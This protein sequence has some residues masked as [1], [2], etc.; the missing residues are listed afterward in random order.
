MEGWEDRNV[1]AP[2]RQNDHPTSASSC[3]LLTLQSSNTPILQ[4][5]NTPILQYS[6]TPILQYSNTPESVI[7]RPF[8]N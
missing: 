6:N 7:L 2:R 8:T 5:S 4:Y 1:S 3:V